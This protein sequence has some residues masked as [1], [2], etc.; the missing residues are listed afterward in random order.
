MTILE[1][2]YLSTDEIEYSRTTNIEKVKTEEFLG[3]LDIRGD[4]KEH[5]IW[6]HTGLSSSLQPTGSM[7]FT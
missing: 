2:F 1:F 4:R 7:T 6:W 3:A 5:E